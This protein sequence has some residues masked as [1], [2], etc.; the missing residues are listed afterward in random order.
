MKDFTHVSN[1][2]GYMRVVADFVIQNGKPGQSVLDIP[3]GNGLMAEELRSKGFQVTCADINSERPD[4]VYANMEKVL[5]F[6]DQHFDFVICMEGL[7]H[8]INPDDLVGEL[9]RITKPG[10]SVIISMPNV[11]CLYSR[12]KFLFTGIFYQFEPEFTRHPNG[13]MVDRGHISALSYM[14][15]NYLFEEF[16]LSPSFISGDK[17]KKK[18]LIPIY[19]LAGLVNFLFL[20]QKA[21]TASTAQLQSIYKITNNLRYLLSRSIVAAWNKP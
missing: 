21:K 7:E 17:I 9:S 1:F 3:A 20:K 2:T 10:G 8:V 12:L 5:P 14:Q 11:Q 6:P 18:I 4:Y 15:I 13:A 19:F 16:K